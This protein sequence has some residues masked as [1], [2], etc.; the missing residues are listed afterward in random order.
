[1]TLSAQS[2]YISPED[3]AAPS[4]LDFEL[5]SAEVLLDL[6]GFWESEIIGS[7][8]FGKTGSDGGFGFEP[9]PGMSQGVAFRQT[10]DI[11]IYLLI[12][13]R[14]S[15]ETSF[16]DGY[17]LNRFVLGYD[18]SPGE[19]LERLRIGNADLDIAAYPYIPYGMTPPDSI[20]LEG[21][22]SL[23]ESR[24]D[25]AIRYQP[26]GVVRRVFIGDNEARSESIEPGNYLGGR[27]FVLPDS[28]VSDVELFIESSN[29]SAAQI[30]DEAGRTYEP[31]DIND[32]VLSS[33]SGV[34]EF[35]DALDRRV[36]VFYTKDG[37]NV[38]TPGL[39]IDFLPGVTDERFDPTKGT[40]DFSFSSEIYLGRTME[41]YRVVA[42][43][44][45]YLIL[46]DPG[47]WSPFEHAGYFLLPFV[48]PE[49]RW[50]TSITLSAASPIDADI[51]PSGF[52]MRLGS[53]D[54]RDPLS[55]YPLMVSAPDLY[56][57]S[58][59]DQS[60]GGIPLILVEVLTPIEN[61]ILDSAVPGS[62][63]ITRNGNPE[64]RY[65]L[66]PSGEITFEEAAAPTDRIEIAHQSSS[67]DG[68]GGDIAVGYGSSI[69]IADRTDLVFGFG[70]FWNIAAESYS[71]AASD[72]PG[73][74]VASTEFAHQT[75][76]LTL[77]L[78]GAVTVTSP[79]TSGIFR[80]AGMSGPE[81]S[82]VFSEATIFP[83][84]PPE[85]SPGIGLLTSLN[86]G[87]LLYKD[88]YVT[89]VGGV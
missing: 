29:D 64:E 89:G 45:E 20:G 71:V 12:N 59:I 62:V 65:R 40:I 75:D 85:S 7:I 24:H 68:V 22:L 78:R 70:T 73:S 84:S 19:P 72:H 66:D 11:A 10:P 41:S 6:L 52:A 36:L 23:G 34:I 17:E 3:E 46:F 25:I 83:A 21:T 76:K 43:A 56:G 38:G 77:G 67:S 13:D 9:F 16:L 48:V 35:P 69:A 30:T 42:D 44:K 88:F 27:Y 81:Q 8:G 2:D 61:I 87:S 60:P 79:D 39:G 1:M 49:E 32:V 54:Q 26:G 55:R 58:A 31:L 86:R 57:S 33:G 74:L 53:G 51:V 14:Y 37:A 80:I 50:R 63:R 47:Q 18:G 4:L 28:G 5:G 15:F 82:Y